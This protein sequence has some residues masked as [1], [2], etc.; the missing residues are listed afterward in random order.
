MV[1]GMVGGALAV[2][3]VI[4][5][6]GVIQDFSV[7]IMVVLGGCGSGI[8]YGLFSASGCGWVL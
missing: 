6:R 3:G 4:T 2:G 5:R 1:V 8:W 7:V